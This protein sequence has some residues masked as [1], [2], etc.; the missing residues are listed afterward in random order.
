[1]TSNQINL[2]YACRN[3]NYVDNLIARA[4]FVLNYNAFLISTRAP[5]NSFSISLVDWCS[6]TPLRDSLHLSKH[7]SKIVSFF[8]VSED[9]LDDS[10]VANSGD[11]HLTCAYNVAIRRSCSTFNIL[12]GIDQI[13]NPSSIDNLVKLFILEAPNNPVTESYGIIPRRLLQADLSSFTFDETEVS[14]YLDTVNCS[15][16]PY[17]NNKINVGTGVGGLLLKTS[18]LTKL[19]GFNQSWGGYGGSDVDLMSRVSLKIGHRDLSNFGITLFKLPRTAGG[20]RK[21]KVSQQIFPKGYFNPFLSGNDVHWG[22]ANKKI[23]P[24]QAVCSKIQGK[25]VKPLNIHNAPR[26]DMGRLFA[27]TCAK[28]FKVPAYAPNL[29]KWNKSQKNKQTILNLIKV[30][31]TSDCRTLWITVNQAEQF[32]LDI[33]FLFPDISVVLLDQVDDADLYDFEK[34]INVFL[35]AAEQVGHYGNIVGRPYLEVDRELL[36]SLGEN[37]SFGVVF[38]SE[39]ANAISDE[40]LFGKMDFSFVKFGLIVEGVD[41][42]GSKEGFAASQKML[43]RSF[44]HQ[45]KNSNCGIVD[46]D[47]LQEVKLP[48]LMAFAIQTELVLSFF[49]VLIVNLIKLLRNIRKKLT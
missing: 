25:E 33:L 43:Q 37:R 38:V 46:N 36:L 2:I 24:K 32:L 34:K 49:D 45:P 29:V 31:S 48:A 17:E 7:A 15:M 40:I 23:I 39:K 5:K 9:N 35:R 19:R 6:E 10:L 21:M 28:R 22:L 30:F 27:F 44:W 47:F 41:V 16:M 11:M 13:F 20:K 4:S 12:S 42:A 26:F 1:M 3:D 14:R 18:K 8:E